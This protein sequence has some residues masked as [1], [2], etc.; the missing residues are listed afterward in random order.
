MVAFLELPSLGVREGVPHRVRGGP[1]FRLRMHLKGYDAGDIATVGCR[2]HREWESDAR[3][4]APDEDSGR[5]RAGRFPRALI[6]LVRLCQE[7]L[8][9]RPVEGRCSAFAIAEDRHQSADV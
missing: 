6:G 5:D 1:G 9:G 4:H 8:G 2:L 3:D 7:A